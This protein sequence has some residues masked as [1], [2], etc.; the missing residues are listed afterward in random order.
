MKI[1]ENYL[2]ASPTY[3]PAF[4]PGFDPKSFTVSYITILIASLNML[5][6]KTIEY[7]LESASISLKIARTDT[8]SVA[9]IRDPNANDSFIEN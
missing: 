8:G 6:P 1:A 9:E 7:K 3:S 2:T 5:S 4:I